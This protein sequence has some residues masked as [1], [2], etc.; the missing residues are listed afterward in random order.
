VVCH[1]QRINYLADVLGSRSRW[2][3]WSSGQRTCF[4][5]GRFRVQISAWWPVIP[6]GF[7]GS[8]PQ[9]KCQD[10]ILIRARP[11][12]SYRFHFTIH[13]QP[14][15]RRSNWEVQLNKT[16]NN[17]TVTVSRFPSVQQY[18]SSGSH[19]PRAA[20]LGTGGAQ[21]QTLPQT[22]FHA[23]TLLIYYKVKLSH[24]TPW[25]RL[26]VRGGIAPTHSRPRHYMGVS[27]QRHALATL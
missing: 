1:L 6:I 7:R 3:S 16:M 21:T 25:R 13:N 2:T 26:R 19:R 9:G 10:S 17:I 20:L 18:Q 14:I 15:I 8:A 27:G 5:F 23:L 11:L 12:P 4:V 24:Y 22:Y